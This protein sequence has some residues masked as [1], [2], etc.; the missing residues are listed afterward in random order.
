MSLTAFATTGVAAKTV[1]LKESKVVADPSE[2]AYEM[3][4]EPV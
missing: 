4:A 2:H 3:T 1:T